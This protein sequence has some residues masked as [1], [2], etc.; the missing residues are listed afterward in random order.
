MM[1]YFPC[2]THRLVFYMLLH[3][4]ADAYAIYEIHFNISPAKQYALR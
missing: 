4:S 3:R 2:F 1:N